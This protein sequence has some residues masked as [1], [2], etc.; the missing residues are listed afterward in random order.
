[1]STATMKSPATPAPSKEDEELRKS[2]EQ[3]A[4]ELE[5]EENGEDEVSTRLLGAAKEI[6]D[7]IEECNSIIEKADA[8]R[9][10]AVDK[11]TSEY[12]STVEKAEARREELKVQFRNALSKMQSAYGLEPPKQRKVAA[13]PKARNT[14]QGKSVRL[15]ITELL[16]KKRAATTKEIKEFLQSQGKTTNPGVELTRMVK[17]GAIVNKQRGHYAIGKK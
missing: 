4:A 15:L 14:R 1:M 9:Q 3:E 7:E 17:S 12:Q 10:A 2:M 5:Q 8:E 11:I 16:E 6:T 13:K